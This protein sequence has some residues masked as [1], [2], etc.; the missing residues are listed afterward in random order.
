MDALEL[1]AHPVRLRIVHAMAGQR[2]LTTAQLCEV[3][4]DVSKATV[5]RHVGM[6]AEAGIL[7]VDG[8]ERVRGAV[9]RRYRLR[10]ERAAIEPE[11]MGRLSPEEHRRVFAAAVATLLAEFAAYVERDNADPL[12]DAV[13]YRQHAVWLDPQEL[14]ELIAGMRAALV[15]HLGN[16]PAPGRRRYLISPIQFPMEES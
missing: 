3:I 11:A 1:F 6:L 9:E 15:P 14:Q 5:Y 12:A 4:Q 7:E 10:G 8:E 16:A 13:G 2:T